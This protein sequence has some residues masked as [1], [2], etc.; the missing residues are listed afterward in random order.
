MT[1]GEPVTTP[2]RDRWCHHVEPA[3]ASV[4]CSGEAHRIAWR[5]GKLVLEDHDLGAE[6]TMLAFGGEMPACLA[7]LQLWRNLHTWAMASDLFRQMQARM[8]GDAL[9]GPGELAAAHQLGLALTWERAWRRT[10]YFS[11]HGRLLAEQL[12]AKAVASFREHLRFWLRQRGSRRLSSVQVEVG[13]SAPAV[14]TGEMDSVGVRAVATLSA[15]WLVAVWGRG[16]AVV[17]GAFVVDIDVGPPDQGWAPDG[18]LAVRAVRWD[19]DPDRPGC[20]RPVDVAAVVTGADG[21]TPDRHL[22]WAP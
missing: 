8:E 3:V 13:R 2:A 11:D 17:D 9:F 4:E 16:L 20:F 12:R 6:Q 15:R 18:G 22:T 1:D 14:V 7:T 21:P 19:A 10:D 5:R